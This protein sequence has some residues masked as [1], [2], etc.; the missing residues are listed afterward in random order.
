MSVLCPIYFQR[1]HRTFQNVLKVDRK[2]QKMRYI[3]SIQFILMLSVVL[4]GQDSLDTTNSMRGV[5][6]GRVTN[7]VD[8]LPVVNANLVLRGTDYGS[9]TDLE[10]KFRIV[11]I[12]TGTY[13]IQV[14][15]LGFM[16]ETRTDI[17]VSNARPV[18]VNFN[19]EPAPIELKEV[20]V[21]PGFFRR[22]AD[23]P[24]SSV[25]QS[26]E[27]IRRLP[28]GFEDVSRAVA[29]LPGI[30]QVGPG[31]NDLIVRGG[32]PSENLFL[33]DNLEIPNI[34]HFGTQGSGGGPQSFINLDYV[35]RID[36]SSGGFGVRY[37]DRLSSMLSIDIRDPRTDRLGGKATISASQFGFDLEGPIKADRSSFLFT[38]RRS[39]LDFIFKLA[40]FA[41]VP[42]Y[43]DFL[44]KSNYEI[45][46]LNRLSLIGITEIDNIRQFN[47][48]EDQRYFNS[49]IL[50]NSQDQYFGGISWRHLFSSGYTNVILGSNNVNYNA[51]QSD[52]LLTPIFENISCEREV[53]LKSELVWN[54]IYT[55]RLVTGIIGKLIEFEADLFLRPY[56]TTY[57]DS[58]TLDRS[59]NTKTTKS[60]IY[61][62]LSQ[63][64]GKFNLTLG[65][66]GDNFALLRDPWVFAPRL[67]L[68]YSH[69][70]FTTFNASIGRYHQAP[71]YIWLTANES[72]RDLRHISVDQTVLSITHLLRYDVKVQVEGYCKSYFD[73]PAS[74]LRPYLIMSNTGG[75]FG[76]TSDGFTSYGFDPLISKGKGRSRGIELLVQKKM[77]EH[78]HYGTGSITYSET[79]FTALD[80]VERSG[81]FD[82]RWIF[83]LAWGFLFNQ[84]W[85]LAAKFRLVTG[86][87]YTPFN[88]DGTQDVAAYHSKRVDI[89]H[90]LDL[91]LDRYWGFKTTN[92][93]AYLDIQN[94][95]NYRFKSPPQWDERNERVRANESI[96]L[97]PSIG[98]SLEF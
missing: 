11:N 48:D 55:T 22:T 58:L 49:Y 82:Q 68:T 2:N 66:R 13:A 93:I 20:K 73:Y 36:F 37:G 90:S 25:S 56:A 1:V 94:I 10:G 24:L 60:A 14:S 33:V 92:L 71:S 47:N 8:N 26:N 85:E 29:V 88:P 35:D 12:P 91:R 53:Y 32:A 27:E 38:A 9:A 17:L 40:G 64:I 16:P 59:F 39:Y 34:N 57:G 41:F 81:K 96:G 67:A 65:G 28:G 70:P 72:N 30:S 52:S 62:Q 42:E 79:Y 97:L 3:I 6:F 54:P 61:S 19:L 89:N 69:T 76:G 77:A 44:F 4:Y 50:A 95:Y 98:V 80:G 45:D 15:I 5:L 86:Q 46:A 74:I 51:R 21:T 31:R 84:K 23:S 75:D 43:W 7:S 18:E 63:R 87:P 78:P 83:N